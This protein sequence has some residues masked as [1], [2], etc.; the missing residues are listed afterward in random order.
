MSQGAAPSPACS[1]SHTRTS[2]ESRMWVLLSQAGVLARETCPELS[3]GVRRC[4]V[5][6]WSPPP[7]VWVGKVVLFPAREAGVGRRDKSSTATTSCAA[8][9]RLQVPARRAECCCWDSLCPPARLWIIPCPPGVPTGWSQQGRALS[10]GQGVKAGFWQQ[11]TGKGSEKATKESSVYCSLFFLFSFTMA[12]LQSTGI[13]PECSVETC[14]SPICRYLQISG[15][16][17]TSPF[18]FARSLL[19]QVFCHI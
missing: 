9:R 8:Q 10:T 18:L 14:A 12:L 5:L 15:T 2:G 3:A 13:S 11:Q 16:P 19:V 4:K 7:G 1:G 17:A 6:L